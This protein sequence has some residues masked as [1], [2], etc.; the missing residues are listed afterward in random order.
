MSEKAYA[1]DLDLLDGKT[2][3][4]SL[5]RW[6]VYPG[7]GEVLIRYV[8]P[9]EH[10]A[11]TASVPGKVTEADWQWW[12][13]HVSDWRGFINPSNG[14]P[15]PFTAARLAALWRLDKN[16]KGWLIAE[17]QR[18]DNFRGPSVAAAAG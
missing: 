14:E 17:A 7:G 3:V 11:W 9:D 5:T 4:E 10:A 8:H 12:Q 16:F 6:L 2:P 13:A 1:I 15:I 18:F